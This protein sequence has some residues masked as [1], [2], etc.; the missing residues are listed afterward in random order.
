MRKDTTVNS[1]SKKKRFNYFFYDF[2]KITGII[3]V[4]LWLHPH[5]YH[6]GDKNKHDIKGPMLITSNHVGYRDPLILLCA[7][8][9]RRIFSLVTKD[10][11]KTKIMSFML[12]AIHCVQVDKEN[13][14]M[15][16][17]HKVSDLLND[18]RAV[19]IFP[20]GQVNRE[21]GSML[22]FKT[23]AV[24]M[25]HKNNAPVLPVYISTGE[26]WYHE[27]IVVIG[28]PIDI[29]EICGDFPTMDALKR[30]SEHIQERERQ[31]REYCEANIIRLNSK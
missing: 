13:F 7:F 8:F 6:M 1:R 18:G 12:N 16:S 23:G 26:K 22:S 9:K 28:D 21:E 3:P 2:V 14:S 4:W 20:E 19:L 27:N 29:R 30:A 31:L 25:A 10:L 5:V 11:Y 24:L 17:F 15:Q